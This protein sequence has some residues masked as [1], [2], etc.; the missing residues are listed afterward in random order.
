MKED[1]DPRLHDCHALSDAEAQRYS[2]RR[3]LF[4]DGCLSSRTRSPSPFQDQIT[5][6]YTTTFVSPGTS[7]SIGERKH[8]AQ[9]TRPLPTSVPKTRPSQ[10]Q[11]PSPRRVISIY[12]RYSRLKPNISYH[13]IICL[14]LPHT[15]TLLH[16]T[17]T[18]DSERTAPKN[19]SLSIELSHLTVAPSLPS[20]IN[21]QAV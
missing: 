8:G 20:D 19:P 16:T 12:I 15:T 1:F 21:H 2:I 13:T 11:E 10:A 4:A 18:L 17:T 6:H 9:Q 3:T 7:K 5:N 14:T